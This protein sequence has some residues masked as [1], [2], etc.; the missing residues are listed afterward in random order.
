MFDNLKKKRIRNEYEKATKVL[1][2]S[3]YEVI[4]SVL[5]DELNEEY[6]IDQIKNAAAIAVNNLGL[7]PESRPNLLND[8]DNLAKSLSKIINT[9]LIKEAAALI[10]IF[11]YFL[12]NKKEEKYLTKAKNLNCSDF[13]TIYN[14]LDIDKT[15]LA[16]VRNIAS[17]ISNKL[18]ETAQIDIMK[19]L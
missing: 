10:L 3:L 18:H 19:N 14:M 4:I 16:K 11:S 6:N 7:R 13:E 15:T 17:S 12:T 5:K 1:Q 8:N 2:L 9:T